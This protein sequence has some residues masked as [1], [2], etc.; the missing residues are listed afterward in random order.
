M[1]IM[2]MLNTVLMRKKYALIS[3]KFLLWK[4]ELML[5]ANPILSIEAVCEGGDL[6]LFLWKKITISP[7]ENIKA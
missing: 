7:S 4:S 3:R 1:F 6:G 5:F 2:K